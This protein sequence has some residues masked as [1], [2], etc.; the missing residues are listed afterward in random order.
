ML[1]SYISIKLIYITVTCLYFNFSN[2]KLEKDLS[3]IMRK[4]LIVI[5]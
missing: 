4:I 5:T 1:Q 3:F 2:I